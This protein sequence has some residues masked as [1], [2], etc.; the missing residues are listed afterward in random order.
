MTAPMHSQTITTSVHLAGEQRARLDVHAQGTPEGYLI[1]LWGSL[2]LTLS[3]TDQARHLHQ[4]FTRAAAPTHGL[5]LLAP[6]QPGGLDHRLSATS[7]SVR[8]WGQPAWG[9]THR[10]AIVTTARRVIPTHVA[11][12]IG[13]ITFQVA[14]RTAYTTALGILARTA[15]LADAV[16]TPTQP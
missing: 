15:T 1:V 8:L 6:A 4:V 3:A 5:P 13:G 10:P 14:D 11:I 2:M 9:I 16:F 7:T 12:S